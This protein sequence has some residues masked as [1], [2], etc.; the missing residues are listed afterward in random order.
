MP[1]ARLSFL[2]LVRCLAVLVVIGAC[3]PTNVA[4]AA[5]PL[6][7]NR[8]IGPILS[9]NCFACHGFDEKARQAEL[10]LDLAESA[11]ADRAGTAAIVPGSAEKS[12]AWRRITSSDPDEQMPPPSSNLKLTDEEKAKLRQWI[13]EG[14][15]YAAHWSF[16]P[17]VKADPS[18]VSRP[19]W[20]RNAIDAFVLARLDAEGL[21]PAA[22]ADRRMYIRRVS[23]DLIGLPPTAEEVEAFVNDHEPGAYERLVDRLLASPHFGEKLAL[24]W[25]DAAR[26]ADTNGFSID[27][28]RQQW[29]WRDWV[30]HAFN[31]NLPYDRFLVEQLA[32]DLLPDANDS[33]LIATGFQR[34]NMVTHEGGTI[35]EEN[36][37][38]YNA[39]R[40]KTLGEAVL[41]LTLG[42]AQCHD[43]KYDPILQRDYY[44]LF[45]YF[46]TASDVGLDGNGGVD[47]KPFKALR[48]VL[49]TGEEPS[50]AKQLA[51]LRERLEHPDPRQLAAWEK[52]QHR[53]L[54]GRGKHLRLLPVE[55]L[56]LSTPNRG[57]GFEIEGTR[58]HIQQPGDLATY[59]VSLKLPATKRPITGV[60]VVF[61]PDKDAPQGG[62]GFGPAEKRPSRK[63][64]PQKSTKA[65]APT[66]PTD[67]DSPK[68]T[69]PPVESQV[70]GNFVL[71]A[72]SASADA[73]AGDQVNLYRLLAVRGVTANS[74]QAS[75]PPDGCL[76]MRNDDGWSSELS[77]DGPVHLTV[78]FDKPLSSAETPFVTVQ[79]NF[80]HGKSL[81]AAQF[82]ILAM[83]GRDDGSPLPSDVIAILE[84][85]ARN[86]S[87]AQTAQLA[88][89]FAAHAPATRAMRVAIANL[90]ERLKVQT[91]EFP[92]MV[93]DTAAKPRDTFI[94]HRGD[95]AQP[96]DKVLAGT[97]SMLPAL[98][99]SPDTRLGL[100]QWITMPS[101]PLTARVAVNR[102][103]AMLFGAGIVRTSADFGSQAEPPT[104]PELLD[105]LAVD[106]VEHGWDVKRL[107]RTIVL[108]ATY[109][110]NSAATPKMLEHDP[111]N[112]LLA[113]G[114]RFRLSAELVRDAAL[115]TSGLL[116]PRLGGPGVNPYTPG[117]LWREISH[118]GST[119]ATAQTFVQDHGEKLYRRSLYT[120]W[121][122]TA[123]PP[124][125]AAFDAPNREVCVVSRAA[126][127]TP[128]QALVLLND[129]QFVEA[130]RALAE[131]IMAHGKTD[132]G[133]LRW[134]FEECLSRR[135]NETEL[136]VVA[137]ALGRERARYAA[138]ESAARA[139]LANGESPRD[140][141]IPAAEHAAWSQ[142]AA[143]LLNLSE[144][145]TRN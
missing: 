33:T 57:S 28:G 70:K 132:D 25:L 96:G 138:D 38:N 77:F 27:G 136:S 117:D 124:N 112:R 42:C 10:R 82:E 130:S 26:Y 93:M 135:P 121:K 5:R 141:S 142:I 73:V 18:R 78:T 66:E 118:Y 61:Y 137:K 39:D 59:D 60:R 103:W 41:G 75:Y 120:F 115:A 64:P 114:P 140:Q 13:D 11:T 37:V 72:F 100:A 91:G 69:P 52:Q 36:L 22:E 6:D 144:A 16:V 133:R 2:G 125:M 31:S 122:R 126:T 108:S 50:V 129:V 84:T 63:T 47:P 128:L 8:D 90:D 12:E 143:L 71:T 34:N 94:L 51:A 48:T 35:P 86:R 102:F 134:A 111:Q 44:R 85:T 55:P 92:T 3:L 24:D 7:F 14:G 4:W 107:L 62:W 54:A 95:Y 20:V 17:P 15:K 98:D 65:A 104:H 32:G 83:T 105:W 79:L 43:H 127:N 46:N 97:P 29:L 76:D 68:P 88:G 101:N 80:G 30:I 109:R 139:Y 89:Y 99:G 21:E 131:R 81:V 56:K 23:F 19:Q 110:Q 123:P 40:V 53:K 1:R 116:V 87:A 106:F 67:E 113:R 145:V 49:R 74:W 45:A 119:P 9:E 58:I